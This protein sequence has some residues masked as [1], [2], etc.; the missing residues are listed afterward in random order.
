MPVKFTRILSYK[1]NPLMFPLVSHLSFL[2]TSFVN[3]IISNPINLYI[4][5]Q[6]SGRFGMKFG[7]FGKCVKKEVGVY[8]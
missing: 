1:F 2:C 6:Q 4:D 3:S 7:I 5:Y 8:F